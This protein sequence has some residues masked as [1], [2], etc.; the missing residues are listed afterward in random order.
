MPTKSVFDS[1]NEPCSRAKTI[2]DHVSNEFC[3]CTAYIFF[4]INKNELYESFFSP[5]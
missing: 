2:S 3:V 1:T 5:F 4:K